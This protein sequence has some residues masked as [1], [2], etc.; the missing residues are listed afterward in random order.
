MSNFTFPVFGGNWVDLIV[1]FVI[2]I[3]FLDGLRRGFVYQFFSFL[4]FVVAFGLALRVYPF[5][6]KLLAGNFSLPIGIANGLGFILAGF[7]FEL[8]LSFAVFFIVKKGF[9]E[10][11][12]S[13]P[14]LKWIKTADRILGV[15]PSVLIALVMLAFVLTTI[16]TLPVRG[17]IKKSV[18]DS[19][20][21]APIVQKTS[22]IE[23]DF[24]KIFGGVIEDSLTFLTVKPH[25]GETID[26][27]FTQNDVSYDEKSEREMWMLINEERAKVGAK[28]LEFDRSGLTEA[29]RKHGIDMF[30]RGYFSHVNPDGEDPFDRL[31]KQGISYLLAAENLAYAPDVELAHKGLM[32]SPGHRENI[33]NPAFGKVGIGVVDGGIYGKMFVQEFTD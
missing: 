30:T 9:T 32:D 10:K 22:G 29:A 23:R 21:G 14:N 8:F 20:I 25:E 18:L 2:F 33:L 7:L 13:S 5:F 27:K 11:I 4:G 15:I 1:F 6:G 12:L 16:I 24:A 26:L 19:K 17:D 28:K 31:E 3:Y